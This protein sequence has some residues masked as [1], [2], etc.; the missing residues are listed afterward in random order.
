MK[1]RWIDEI[2]TEDDEEAEWL[3]NEEA[4]RA[5]RM[6]GLLLVG[7][8]LVVLVSAAVILWRAVIG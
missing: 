2:Y 5:S 4:R 7:A 8:M 6:L 1:G 3:A